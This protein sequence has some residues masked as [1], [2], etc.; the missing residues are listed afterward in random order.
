MLRR[1]I[2][3]R[4]KTRGLRTERRMTMTIGEIEI[5][6]YARQLLEAHGEKAIVEAAQKARACDQQG[7]SEKAETWRQVEAALKRMRGP[8]QS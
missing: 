4:E 8:H 3:V 1:A 6:D 5:H 7:D 2:A